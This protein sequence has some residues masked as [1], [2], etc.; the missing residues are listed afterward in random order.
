MGRGYQ[1]QRKIAMTLNT[2]PFT[3]LNILKTFRESGDVPVKGTRSKVSIGGS[4][5]TALKPGLILFW[6]HCVDQEHFGSLSSVS[7][8]NE[9]S[10]KKKPYVNTDIV[11]LCK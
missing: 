5:S 4:S 6:N 10:A 9:Y 8:T 3:D 7:S 2:P 11:M 1:S